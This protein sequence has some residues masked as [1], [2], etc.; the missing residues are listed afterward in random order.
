MKFIQMQE[1]LKKAKKD[2]K[3]ENQKKRDVKLSH[4]D[5]LKKVMEM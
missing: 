2:Q 4:E 3:K 5:F 1:A